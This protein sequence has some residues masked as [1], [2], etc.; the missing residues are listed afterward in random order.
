MRPAHRHLLAADASPFPCDP[1]H[2]AGEERGGFAPRTA[3]W[4]GHAKTA[5]RANAEDVAPGPSYTN[6]FDL[7]LLDEVGALL[8]SERD[9]IRWISSLGLDV[10]RQVGLHACRK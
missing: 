8:R 9:P 3:P 10:K 4:D 2:L 1:G 7:L 6:E 5:V